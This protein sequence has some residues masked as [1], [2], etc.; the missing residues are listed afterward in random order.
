[1]H[2]TLHPESRQKI[3]LGIVL[4]MFLFFCLG[5]IKLQLIQHSQ[6]ARQSDRNHIRVV[7]LVPPRGE[8]TD[9]TG[10]TIITNRPSFTVTVI[11]A[12]MDDGVP[13]MSLSWL[14]GL[15]TA[16]ISFRVRK[17]IQSR[18]LPVPVRRDA[19][20]TIIAVLEE[21]ADRFPGVTYLVEQAREY[22]AGLLTEGFTGYVA[23]ASRENVVRDSSKAR[24]D[25]YHMLPIDY[26]L[27]GRLV[28]REGLEKQYDLQLRGSEGT[29]YKE[30]S[31]AV[32][33]RGEYE[34]KMEAAVVGPTVEM[35]IDLDL[36]AAA[37][38][39]LDTFCCG[40]V[41]AL[42]PRN[43]EVLALAS[44][45]GYD[46]NIFSSVV[47]ESLWQVI[48]ADPR[49]PLLNRPLKGLYP[50]GST[51]KP[52][53][54]GAAL[55]EGVI[56]E[57][58]TLRACTGGMPF[59]N[60]VFHCWQERGHGSLTAV[61]AIEQSCDVFM[62]QL[63]VKMGV[64][65]LSRYYDKCGFGYKTRID[66]PEEAIGNN[67]NT[68]YYDTNYGKGKW[69]KA[70]V[71]N[72]S[73]GQGEVLVTPLQLAQF[74]CGLA[75]N[76]VVCRPHLVRRMAYPDGRVT[77]TVPQV[78][79]TLPFSPRTLSLL[80]EALRLVVQG[81]GGTARS[82]RNPQYSLGGKTGT[83]QNPHG[84]DHSWFVGIAP[85]EAPEIV[86][87]AIVENAGHGSEIAAP[88]VGKIIAKYMELRAERPRVAAAS[89]E[90]QP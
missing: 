58:T 19:S 13:P 72:N 62:Y 84:R 36:Q 11:P 69:S 88:T 51:I 79:F 64:D 45:P 54:V 42:D 30:V 75:N 85:L 83:A 55:E 25:Q 53:T 76:G 3:L 61:H 9:R 7:P 38:A 68:E 66:L 41:V 17:N 73:I 90:E 15:D 77:A 22:P 70:L 35:T 81:S 65:V 18:Y 29:I 14:L 37:V 44:F 50:P 26:R 16:E 39:A 10:R 27:L 6:L 20:D 59:G 21:Q 1:M 74:Y 87:C 89:D 49:H 34:S 43:G 2:R 86:V 40:A 52:L 46:A 33:V 12:E 47:P 31:A 57:T 60:R 23:E 67:P 24:Q 4:A 56:D 32:Q 80:N 63:G 48:S 8:V 28:G 78:S 82:L 71:L 5:L